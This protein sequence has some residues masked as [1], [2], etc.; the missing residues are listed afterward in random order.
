MQS[1][2]ESLLIGFG[3]G[4]SLDLVEIW[5]SQSRT[6]GLQLDIVPHNTLTPLL[7]PSNVVEFADNKKKPK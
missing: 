6:L 4:V 7:L 5:S 3:H 1:E 2:L